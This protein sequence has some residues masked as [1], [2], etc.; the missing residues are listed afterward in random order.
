[1]EFKNILES[2]S[3]VKRTLQDKRKQ[4][5]DSRS[6][7]P[8][9]PNPT[10]LH[11]FS[12][13]KSRN[14]KEN[15]KT[16]TYSSNLIQYQ[17]YHSMH[18][19]DIPTNRNQLIGKYSNWKCPLPKSKSR[20]KSYKID[21][22]ELI[23][24][25]L[26]KPIKRYFL[27]IKKTG[28]KEENI[29]EK[30]DLGKYF[31]GRSASEA[32]K[33]L[34]LGFFD[35]KEKIDDEASESLKDKAPYRILAPLICYCL[36]VLVNKPVKTAFAKIQMYGNCRVWKMF[37][38]RINLVLRSKLKGVVMSVV[39]PVRAFERELEMNTPKFYKYPKRDIEGLLSSEKNMKNCYM[40]NP[41][42]A[43]AER[44]FSSPSL[45]RSVTPGR[46]VKATAIRA[47]ELEK[48]KISDNENSEHNP[49]FG[50][51]TETSILSIKNLHSQID[52]KTLETH[53]FSNLH[54]SSDFLIPSKTATINSLNTSTR[55]SLAENISLLTNSANKSKNPSNS[56]KNLIS[57]D[58][59]PIKL[60]QI[61]T[62]SETTNAVEDTWNQSHIEIAEN[63]EDISLKSFVQNENY[64][65]FDKE[66]S[67]IKNFSI[68]KNRS[69][70]YWANQQKTHR[71]S[72]GKYEK[73][74]IRS[75]SQNTTRVL[76]CN[77]IA[78]KKRLN[79]I[80]RLEVL[81]RLEDVFSDK[82][83]LEYKGFI[84]SMWVMSFEG[85]IEKMVKTLDLMLMKIWVGIKIVKPRKKFTGSM[86]KIWNWLEK[87]E[88][89]TKTMVV[90]KWITWAKGQVSIE[91][92]QGSF[93]KSHNWLLHKSQHM[94]ILK[95]K[96]IETIFYI[97][98]LTDFLHK[99]IILRLSSCFL[100]IKTSYQNPR[101]AIIKNTCLNLKKANSLQ[102]K[103]D[104]FIYKIRALLDL[105]LIFISSFIFQNR[106]AK[107]L[108]LIQKNNQNAVKD[109]MECWRFAARQKKISKPFL[110]LTSFCEVIKRKGFPCFW[111]AWKSLKNLDMAKQ[112]VRQ[113]ALMRKC[114]ENW[115]GVTI[116]RSDKWIEG[117]YVW[118][119]CLRVEKMR[120]LKDYKIIFS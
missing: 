97:K 55:K 69:L 77:D 7:S 114:I 48:S 104:S 61:N 110:V 1:M 45:D 26:K 53:N 28:E 112:K 85:A 17:N 67:I 75:Q 58:I 6:I 96:N 8:N 33:S 118:R 43:F 95:Q 27:E 80:A 108:E 47:H 57:F 54:K 70:K 41:C 119:S 88:Y 109:Y 120:K 66:S 64:T 16:T 83:L 35:G 42:A 105:K 103:Y 49:T 92:Q 98:T 117:F 101:P 31:R 68:E 100:T 79:F 59:S 23:C 40:G 50:P 72:P 5:A 89:R 63:F 18:Q 76:G 19:F 3:K 52:F 94:H 56:H 106:Y 39:K 71:P 99:K 84:S 11:S 102:R 87:K 60:N 46:I 116:L 91:K 36:K 14:F 32:K 15:F 30:H 9:T 82:M 107:L 44:K 37:V 111:H 21:S 29:G 34:D 38:L 93:V 73:S 25:C 113:K 20:Q 10:S 13:K 24:L 12:D 51:E 115:R 22:A 65:I 62:L 2:V 90:K 86:W 74:F 81:S 78:K 4:S